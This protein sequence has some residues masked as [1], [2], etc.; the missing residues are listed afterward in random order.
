MLKRAEKEL[1]WLT[2]NFPKTE[3]IIDHLRTIINGYRSILATV[4]TL[5]SGKTASVV[6][7]TPEPAAV[8]TITPLVTK[9]EIKPVQI[10]PAETKTRKAPTKGKIGP[11]EL[12][13]ILDNHKKMNPNQIGKALGVVPTTIIYHLKKL[14]LRDSLANHVPGGRTDD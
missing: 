1:Q 2:V 13:F 10:T 3:I 9:P 4:A 8:K 12:T 7:I 14:G 5:D 6:S 11:N